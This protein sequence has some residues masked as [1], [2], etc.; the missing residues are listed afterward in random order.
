MGDLVQL[1]VKR[2]DLLRAA[3][4]AAAAGSLG[5][6][7]AQ[8]VHQAVAEEKSA[9]AYKPNFFRPHEFQTLEALTEMTIPGARKAGAPEFIDLLCSGSEELGAIFTGGLLWMD[10]YMQRKHRSSW[11]GSTSEQQRALLDLIAYKKN[12]TD[13]LAP[14]VRFFDWVRRMS[15]DAYYTSPEGVK[16]LGYLGNKGASEFKVPQEA[17]EYALKRSGLG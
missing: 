10:Q 12:Q 4:L 8:H 2:R 9:A 16:E 5:V 7:A 14:G 15:A 1:E 13:E 6:E 11:V 17:Y 3:G